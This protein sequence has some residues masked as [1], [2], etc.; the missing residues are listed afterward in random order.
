MGQIVGVIFVT[1]GVVWATIDTASAT[2]EV[3]ISKK[4]IKMIQ[5]IYST[6]N[7]QTQVT[8]PISLLALHYSSLP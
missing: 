6:S 2:T 5:S 3:N 1:V 7:R 8:R 4:K